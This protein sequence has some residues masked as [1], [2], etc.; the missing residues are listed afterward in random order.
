MAKTF[1]DIFEVDTSATPDEIRAA[2][3]RMVQRHHPDKNRGHSSSEELLKAINY[4]YSVLSDARKRASYDSK[5]ASSANGTDRATAPNGADNSYVYS[6]EATVNDDAG[7]TAQ[8]NAA[9]DTVSEAVAARPFETRHLGWSQASRI[10]SW[11]ALGMLVLLFFAV[12]RFFYQVAAYGVLS[13]AEPGSA[14][15]FYGIMI[16]VIIAG[17]TVWLAGKMV[18]YTLPLA[19]PMNL[20]FRAKVRSDL[21]PEH[22]RI[23]SVVLVMGILLTFAV[24][25]LDQQNDLAVPPT[26]TAP[27][28][29]GIMET[30]VTAQNPRKNT[31]VLPEPETASPVIL[32]QNT[33]S[34]PPPDAVAPQGILPLPPVAKKPAVAAEAPPAAPIKAAAPAPSVRPTVEPKTKTPDTPPVAPALTRAAPAT[35]VPPPVPAPAVA[36]VKP[37]EP[38][39]PVAKQTPPAKVAAAVPAVT[40]PPI[41]KKTAGAPSPAPLPEPKTPPPAAIAPAVVEKPAAAPS[42]LALVTPTLT[43]APEKVAVLKGIPAKKETAALQNNADEGGPTLARQRQRAQQGIAEAQYQLGR[44]HEKGEGVARNYRQAENWYRKAADQGYGPAQYSL[45]SMYMLGKG[46]TMDP[47]SAYVWLSLAANNNV[48]SGQQAVDYLVDTLTPVQL[49]DAKRKIAKGIPPRKR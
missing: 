26:A 37:V 41:E 35:A 36:R 16:G 29:D 33:A 25:N 44:A 2:Y 43:A 27:I 46:V 1:Y 22:R 32:A 21:N 28:F 8:A 47:V 17:G 24:P 39:K 5:L 38:E 23:A 11:L 7:Q 49:A 15:L 40:P 10:N 19:W 31:T 4:A 14:T 9:R 13:T 42:A 20:I 34:T 45:G 48:T 18:A 30:P 3:K 12:S 6:G